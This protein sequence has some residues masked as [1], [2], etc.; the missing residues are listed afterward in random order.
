[1]YACSER[2]DSVRLKRILH[3]CHCVVTSACGERERNVGCRVHFP[4]TLQGNS[5]PRQQTACDDPIAS[6][7]FG[8]SSVPRAIALSAFR[9][10]FVSTSSASSSGILLVMQ[11]EDISHTIL[12]FEFAFRIVERLGHNTDS[13]SG[14]GG[15]APDNGN[16]P[17]HTGVLNASTHLY[18]RGK[19]HIERRTVPVNGKR[20]TSADGIG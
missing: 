1:M 9:G 16:V 8:P 3:S 2:F 13:L 15:V 18:G 11:V 17:P 7:S 14:L 20:D 4:V 10:R 12:C 6:N 19:R 5:S